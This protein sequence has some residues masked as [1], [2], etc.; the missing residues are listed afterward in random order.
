MMVGDVVSGAV[1]ATC[2]PQAVTF[3]SVEAALRTP[4]HKDALM[5]GS[6]NPLVT[7]LGPLPVSDPD[8]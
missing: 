1:P 7:T 2:K 4:S 5:R 6:A 8:P 3:H